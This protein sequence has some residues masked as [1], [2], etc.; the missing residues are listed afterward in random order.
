[1]YS[2]GAM[3]VQF[4][5]KWCREFENHLTYINRD[6][7]TCLRSISEAIMNAK[8]VEEVILE[9]R[10]ITIRDFSAALDLSI[11]SVQNTSPD[12]LE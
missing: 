7:R 6:D 4:I 9:H 11:E 1:V 8:T 12:K 10:L 2:D 5:R 3:R